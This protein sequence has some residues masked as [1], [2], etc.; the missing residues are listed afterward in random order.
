ML[1]VK[2]NIFWDVFTRNMY[3][4]HRCWWNPLEIINIV[5]YTTNK[6]ET[7]IFLFHIYDENHIIFVILF[8]INNNTA[9]VM[10][11]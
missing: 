9:Y 3:H 2:E 6:L 7:C 4:H 8:I 10:N 11:I 1:N 5:Q